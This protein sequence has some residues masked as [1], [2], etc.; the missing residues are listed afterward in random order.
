MPSNFSRLNS[1]LQKL[2][3]VYDKLEHQPVNPDVILLSKFEHYLQYRSHPSRS[4]YTEPFIYYGSLAENI[5]PF[6]R[7]MNE[8][9]LYRKYEKSNFHFSLKSGFFQISKL[10]SRKEMPALEAELAEYPRLLQE[11][12]L[13][14]VYHWMIK[15]QQLQDQGIKRLQD[16]YD[17]LQDLLNE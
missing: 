11:V 13:N 16:R 5:D 10:P 12:R 17:E 4:S 7:L 3:A 2:Q 15:N 9:D 14:A 1:S 8:D 6:I